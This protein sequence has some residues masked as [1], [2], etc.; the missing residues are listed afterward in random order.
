M[1]LLAVL[2]AFAHAELNECLG[3]EMTRIQRIPSCVTLFRAC[4]IGVGKLNQELQLAPE[5][6]FFPVSVISASESKMNGSDDT[7][8]AMLAQLAPID[9]CVQ[10]PPELKHHNITM[11]C[12]QEEGCSTLKGVLLCCW[13]FAQSY[14]RAVWG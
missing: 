6:R 7:L 12:V 2:A 8:V 3:I 4:E 11:R 14:V 10:E 5:L 1:A 9:E 13:W